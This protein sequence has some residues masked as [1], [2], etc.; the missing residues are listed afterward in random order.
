VKGLLRALRLFDKLNTPWA[1]GAALVLILVV[2][3][4]LLYRD[5]QLPRPSSEEVFAERSADADTASIEEA[6]NAS[7]EDEADTASTE[8]ATNASPEDEEQKPQVGVRV[9]DDPSFLQ[10]VVDDQTVLQRMVYPELSRKYE[11]DQM[12]SIQA[13]N[14]GAVLLEVDGNNEGR[15]GASDEV[16]SRTYRRSG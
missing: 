6:T 5:Y 14:A 16:V 9:E 4:F 15:L 1:V 13:Y 11:V 2:D 12:F 10:I 3:G 7:P 8:E